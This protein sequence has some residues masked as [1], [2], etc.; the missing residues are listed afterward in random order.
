MSPLTVLIRAFPIT[1]LT[2]IMSPSTPLSLTTVC[3]LTFS[4]ICFLNFWLQ[5]LYGIY[6]FRSTNLFIITVSSLRLIRSYNTRFIITFSRVCFL[7]W[8]I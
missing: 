6:T 2:F 3:N 5:D 8:C 4:C 7:S 1:T